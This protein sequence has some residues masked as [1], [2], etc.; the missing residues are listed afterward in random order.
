MVKQESSQ[1]FL[2]TSKHA[3]SNFVKASL[4]KNAKLVKIETFYLDLCDPF[5]QNLCDICG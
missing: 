4:D 5:A 1:D 2:L 3:K